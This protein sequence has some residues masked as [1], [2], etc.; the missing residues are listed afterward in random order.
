MPVIDEA[1]VNSLKSKHP[2]CDLRQIGDE[3]E[4]PIIVRTPTLAEWKAFKA[5]ARDDNK[6]KAMD[7]PAW[8]VK[9]CCVWPEDA[10]RKEII[11]RK[12]AIVDTWANKLAEFAGVRE[13][14]ASKKL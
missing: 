1:L 7:A 8:L 2:G 14:I 11:D 3:D 12:P 4:D 9:T 13:S 6:A 10:T 5:Q